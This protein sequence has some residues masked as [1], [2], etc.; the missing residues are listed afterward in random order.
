MLSL[1][2]QKHKEITAGK[3]VGQKRGQSGS[4]RSHIKPPGKDE[5]GIQDHVQK[6]SAHG[7]DAGVEGR[8]L[9]AYHVGHDHIQNRRRRPAGDGPQH[10]A[11]RGRPG[12]LIRPQSGQERPLAQSTQKREQDPAKQRTVKSKGGASLHR[13]IILSAQSPA[14]HAGGSHAE[15][16]V[17]R[18]KSQ[19]HRVGQ[20]HSR[21]LHR[22]SQHSHKIGVR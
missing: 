21:V 18:V 6:A 9:G 16:V 17:H 13:L 4:G 10:I 12:H 11:V 3:A 5:D 8:P 20:G 2:I 22:V 1:H 7:A 19:Q 15:Q 14:H